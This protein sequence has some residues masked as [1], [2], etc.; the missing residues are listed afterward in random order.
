MYE[1]RLQHAMAGWL[2]LV[3]LPILSACGSAPPEPA[4]VA[5]VVEA[6][7]ALADDDW[8]AGHD[9]PE[10]KC[11]KCNPELTEGFKAAGD[12]CAEHEF[13]ESAC[14]ICN[15]QT[16]PGEAAAT[17]WCVEHA[18]PE[19]TCTKCNPGLVEAYQAAGDWC[20]EH[21]YPESVCPTCSPVTPPPGV[22]S[23]AFA[24]G[25]VIRFRS[26]EIEQASGIAIEPV[27][28]AQLQTDVECTARIVFD[29]NRL[30]DIRASVPGVVREVR[31]DLGARVDEGDD[32]FVLESTEIGDLQGRL[33]AAREHVNVARA[34]Y[35]RQLALRESEIVSDRQVELARNEV[36]TEEAELRAIE[37]GLRISG[38]VDSGLQGR[39]RERS[40]IAGTV[41]R[42]PAT[43]GTFASNEVSLATIANT[44]I[45]WAWLEV[46]EA[47]AGVVRVG[48]SVEIRVDA[49]PQ[50]E[51]SGTVTWLASEVDTKTRTVAARAEVINRENLLRA[52]QFA[53]ATIRVGPAGATLVVPREAIQRL[54][55]D[56]VVF[57]RTGDETY[58][59]RIV[60]LGRSDRERVEVQGDLRDGDAVVTAGAFL[61]K[62]ELSRESIGAGCCEVVPQGGS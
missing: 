29:R 49:L 20:A 28:S 59:P 7:R 55:D 17:D 58:E 36:E 8:C 25:T 26:A 21:G 61:L 30:A 22:G 39:F 24:P 35:D 34:N 44:S 53:R 4:A 60:S 31:V 2:A 42:R 43:I 11:T 52:E 51:F 15:P 27:R 18:L 1:S 62:T 41:I 14:P 48:Q 33:R 56:S 38:A 13:P 19:S 37:A 46:R 10:S 5:P 54:G 32:L 9:L 47:D 16:P 3:V 40:P 6:A 23:G 57:V 50:R 12:W 45:M